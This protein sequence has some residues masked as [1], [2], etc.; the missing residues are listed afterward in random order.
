MRRVSSNELICRPQPLI[1]CFLCR[2]CSPHSG[3]FVLDHVLRQETP[4]IN[5]SAEVVEG[6]ICLA[7]GNIVGC[8]KPILTLVTHMNI[9]EKAL[10]AI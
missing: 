6:R 4:P 8:F 1:G 3:G 7:S 10:C 5:R 2:P 9:I